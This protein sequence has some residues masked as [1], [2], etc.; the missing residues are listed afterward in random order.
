MNNNWYVHVALVI[1]DNDI[2]LFCTG[3]VSGPVNGD[4]GGGQ[5][6]YNTGPG[7]CHGTV[8]DTF[9]PSEED[10]DC[11]HAAEDKDRK[12]DQNNGSDTYDN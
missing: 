9:A 8:D 10:Q 6:Y 5:P 1:H 12:W 11:G 2:R 4:P 3:D 7:F